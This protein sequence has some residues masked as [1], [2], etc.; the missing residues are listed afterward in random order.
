MAPDPL[1]EWIEEEL[2][3]ARQQYASGA[4][5]RVTDSDVQPG[6]PFLFNRLVTANG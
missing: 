4:G 6:L 2:E 5:V 3:E 1:V